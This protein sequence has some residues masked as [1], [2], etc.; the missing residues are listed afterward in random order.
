MQTF[1]LIAH[2]SISAAVPK[3]AS[4]TG[5]DDST[6]EQR[7]FH[8]WAEPFRPC[9]CE[10]APLPDFAATLMK[11]RSGATEIHTLNRDGFLQREGDV[12]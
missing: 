3:E 5:C 6:P 4:G 9:Q 12:K 2:I 11:A 10:S 1:T 7:I 8:V